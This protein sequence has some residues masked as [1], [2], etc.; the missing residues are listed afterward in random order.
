MIDDDA[1]YFAYDHD[2]RPWGF[3]P[4]WAQRE[5]LAKLEEEMLGSSVEGEV[6]G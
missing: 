3:I 4:G 1:W 5:A 6:E 2:G